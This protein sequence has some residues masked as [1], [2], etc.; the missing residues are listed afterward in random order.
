MKK[1]IL[2]SIFCYS[3]FSSAQENHCQEFID[4]MAKEIEFRNID[5]AKTYMKGFITCKEENLGV[6]NPI[7][8][9]ME[10]ISY[11]LNRTDY[12]TII[13]K[14]TNEKTAIIDFEFNILFT[15]E[16]D[17]LIFV[18]TSNGFY[19]FFNKNDET[20]LYYDSN[21]SQLGNKSFNFLDNFSEDLALFN[22]FN[23]NKV[24]IY[25][26]LNSKGE[27]FYLDEKY[28]MA[29][30][31]QED[32]AI[33]VLNSSHLKSKDI[34]YNFINKDYEPILKK[35]LDLI[36][37]SPFYNGYSLVITKGKESRTGI[38]DKQGNLMFPPEN[39]ELLTPFDKGVAI[40]SKDGKKGLVDLNFNPI[41]GFIFT[42]MSGGNNLNSTS[43]CI[44]DF[45]RL[46]SKFYDY[47][48][49]GIVQK[50]K[51]KFEFTSFEVKIDNN[52][53]NINAYGN[54]TSNCPF[55]VD[56]KGECVKDCQN[57]P[58]DYPISSN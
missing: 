5:K 35:S 7:L 49:D 9:K 33:V 56:I 15:I 40:A 24:L 2:I 11:I 12:Q 10:K 4:K 28:G 38:M 31:F 17:K 37:C 41:T 6:D 1:I 30:P 8:K 45:C 54:C 26:Y 18:N 36:I 34:K 52:Y 50:T 44:Y 32:V 57:A 42:R 39:I 16:N 23:A 53:T 29:F 21:G 43:V 22:L 19:K 3:L 58:K 20:Y 46:Q 25:G 27:L 47:V 14:L 51:K 55:Y 13:A 48:Q